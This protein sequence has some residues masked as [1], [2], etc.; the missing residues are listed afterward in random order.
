MLLL[1]TAPVLSMLLVVGLPNE[2][3]RNGFLFV[4][5]LLGMMPV[6]MRTFSNYTLEITDRDHQ[7]IFLST[8]GI[9]MAV[10]V[11]LLSTLVGGMIDWVGFEQTFSLVV[12]IMLLGW[13]LTFK[14]IE[15][16]HKG[17]QDGTVVNSV[18]R[19]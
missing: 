12:A 11:V 15:P 5:F 1:C 3:S 8:L 2:Y 19:D 4:F 18:A 10:P 9:C 16:R 13:T 7:P 17:L 6:S 14:L